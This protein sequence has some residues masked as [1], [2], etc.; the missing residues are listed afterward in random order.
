MCVYALSCVWESGRLSACWFC[1]CSWLRVFTGK[2]VSY[3]ALLR[4][5]LIL[6]R[7]LLPTNHTTGE[8]KAILQHPAPRG[9]TSRW[10]IQSLANTMRWCC[11][12]LYIQMWFCGFLPKTYSEFLHWILCLPSL[13]TILLTVS[14]RWIGNDQTQNYFTSKAVRE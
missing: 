8:H 7:D 14:Y 13:D 12:S 5:I 11:K 1:V 9:R 10:C 2:S 4:P 6:Y 3:K